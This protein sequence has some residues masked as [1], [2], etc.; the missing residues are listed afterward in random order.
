[1]DLV[2]HL[3]SRS[4]YAGDTLKEISTGKMKPVGDR[5]A[6]LGSRLG[7]LTDSGGKVLRLLQ[8]QAGTAGRLVGSGWP[9]VA[10]QTNEISRLA[11]RA[12]RG[13]GT[14]ARLLS[15]NLGAHVA[16]IRAQKDSIS[17]LMNSSRGSL[18]RFRK[19]SSLMKQVSHLQG[20]VDS[21][22]ALTSSGAGL[23]KM[24]SDST[25]TVEMAR[26]REELAALMA[27][28]KKRPVRY[29]K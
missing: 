13:E 21:L 2:G 28:I 10:A 15:G 16:S 25:L 17:A 5:V 24:K 22:R 29:I 18:G 14:F 23:G 26:V 20:Q 9:R 19:D 1:M 3:A 27:D 7:M 4:S 8:S 12:T 6:E 11:K